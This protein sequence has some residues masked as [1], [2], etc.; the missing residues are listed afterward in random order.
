MTH[1]PDKGNKYLIY[2]P[3]HDC[4]RNHGGEC[5]CSK[6]GFRT[7]K[8]A[9]EWAFDNCLCNLCIKNIEN[10]SALKTEE[11]IQAYI[12]DNDIHKEDASFIRQEIMDVQERLGDKAA[13]WLNSDCSA[14][15]WIC[16]EEE[17]DFCLNSD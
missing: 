2:I 14:E 12:T 6:R 3:A 16:N 7:E 8:E 9:A 15:W 1:K 13:L 4:K 5:W 11:D 10:F 17:D